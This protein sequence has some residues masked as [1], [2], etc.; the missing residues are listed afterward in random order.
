M[1][2]VVTAARTRCRADCLKIVTTAISLRVTHVI[3]P[4]KRESVHDLFLFCLLPLSSPCW[5]LLLSNVS[6]KHVYSD[7]LDRFWHLCLLDAEK[8]HA[9][10][11][12]RWK[13]DADGIL[14]F[15]CTRL[16]ASERAL[17]NQRVE[18]PICH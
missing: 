6:L 18:R 15:V 2:V 14:V 5:F 13:G 17:I 10:L 4:E 16:S 3:L 8:Q 1:G 7:P 11:T 12:E 9:K